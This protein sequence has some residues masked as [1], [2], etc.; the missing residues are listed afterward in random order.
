[1]SISK[2]RQGK[3]YSRAKIAGRAKVVDGEIVYRGKIVQSY[4]HFGSGYP[5]VKLENAAW[6][7]ARLV[8]E[9]TTGQPVP[10]DLYIFYK[11][12]NKWNT[13]FENLELRDHTYA[14]S[15]PEPPE[16]PTDDPEL[17]KKIAERTAPRRRKKKETPE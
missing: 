15:D 12:G 13:K 2:G 5:I 1:M 10:E 17:N 11:D 3:A 9:L 7:K 16:N 6:N 8:W 14:K 4:P